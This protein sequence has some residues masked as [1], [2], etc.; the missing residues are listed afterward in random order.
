[1][2]KRK[3]KKRKKKVA[4]SSTLKRFALTSTF[5]LMSHLRR[6]KRG[7]TNVDF[8]VGRTNVAGALTSAAQASMRTYVDAH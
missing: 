8:N 7:R 1:M 3:T 2:K 6:L 5:S 4:L